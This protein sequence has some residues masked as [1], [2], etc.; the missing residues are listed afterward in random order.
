MFVLDEWLKLNGKKPAIEES[1]KEDNILYVNKLN[2]AITGILSPFIFCKYVLNKE[3]M[4]Y[5]NGSFKDLYNLNS[6]YRLYREVYINKKI[7]IIPIISYW[8]NVKKLQYICTAINGDIVLRAIEIPVNET[9]DKL[10]IELFIK[11]YLQT[12]N[13]FGTI[14]VSYNN[15]YSNLDESYINIV[16]QSTFSMINKHFMVPRGIKVGEYINTSDSMLLL[17]GQSIRYWDYEVGEKEIKLNNMKLVSKLLTKTD[18]IKEGSNKQTLKRI[19]QEYMLKLLKEK[20]NI[21]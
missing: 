11:N 15:E 19:K 14:P 21:F 8:N 5:I 3:D 18:I 9:S 4:D 2:T 16:D 1:I 13:N 6:F 7:N 10:F 17:I 20:E 12:F